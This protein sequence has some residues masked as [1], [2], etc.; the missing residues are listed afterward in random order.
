MNRH[1]LGDVLGDSIWVEHD[2]NVL[3]LTSEGPQIDESVLLDKQ[4]I[5]NLMVI[6]PRYYDLEDLLKA[7]HRGTVN[8][9]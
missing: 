7:L 5:E 2:G 1:K 8:H 9:G 3:A 6:L 4:A